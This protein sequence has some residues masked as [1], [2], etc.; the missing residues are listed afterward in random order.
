M[1][2]SPAAL[3]E[4]VSESMSAEETQM[5]ADDRASEHAPREAEAPA[6]AATP[7]VAAATPI[8]EA[9]A[10]ASAPAPQTAAEE[11]T[12]D[13]QQANAVTQER[14]RRKTAEKKL[15]EQEQNAAL[16][17]GR[18]DTLME[19]AR[20]PPEVPVTPQPPTIEVPDYETDP[21]GHLTARTQIAEQA[22]TLA[23][24]RMQQQ[25]QAQQGQAQGSRLRQL[26]EMQENAYRPDHPEYGS[27][28]MFLRNS[29]QQELVLSG[30]SDPVAVQNQINTEI[31]AV[32][33]L[34][35]QQ[36]KTFPEMVATIAQ[37]RGWRPQVAPIPAPAVAEAQAA[38]TPSPA[39]PSPTERL[40][41]V[42]KGQEQTQSIG[43]AAGSP[44]EAP[45]TLTR[46]LN[47]PEAEFEAATR[48]NK[49]RQLME[50]AS[51]N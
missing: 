44:P 29:R 3:P 49:W 17:Q 27:Q 51:I 18:L 36:G 32:A 22:A 33:N 43:Q 19:L 13:Q 5:L 24:Q 46:L 8:P 45:M 37:I 35:Q 15:R 48:G 21:I 47:M 41:T 25:E 23:L 14:E 2:R 10:P 4:G 20:K 11:L 28:A 16:L 38:P 34:A 40:Q 39:A 9:E 50:G 42:A 6:P 26:A 1:A 12:P 30:M 7:E 31:E